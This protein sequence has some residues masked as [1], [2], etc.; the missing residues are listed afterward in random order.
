MAI[1]LWQ[2]RADC[3]VLGESLS[4]HFLLAIMFPLLTALC[5]LFIWPGALRL[6]LKGKRLQDSTAAAIASRSRMRKVAALPGQSREAK[7]PQNHK[8]DR[9][10]G[11]EV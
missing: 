11:S 8:S 7:K 9:A 1:L 10:G 4:F 5:W 6:G 2:M 3:R